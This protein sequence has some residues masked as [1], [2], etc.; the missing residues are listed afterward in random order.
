MTPEQRKL[1]R[2]RLIQRV[3]AVERS[4]SAA[5]ASEAEATRARLSGVA[6]RTRSLAEHYARQNGALV[7]AD[8]RSGKVMRDHLLQLSQISA[9]QAEEADQRSEVVRQEFAQSDRRLRRAEEETR[10]LVR[11]IVTALAKD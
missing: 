3:R 11:S 6:A 5:A 8:L 9:Q 2:A 4:Q 1:K 7:A 10:E